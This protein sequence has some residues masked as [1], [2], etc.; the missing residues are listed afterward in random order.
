MLIRRL[1]KNTAFLA[2]AIAM[3]RLARLIII[4]YIG[5]Y[6]GADALGEYSTVMAFAA[7]F[8]AFAVQSLG[9]LVIRDIAQGRFDVGQY[10]GSVTL[11]SLL[12]SVVLVVM[13]N[14]AARGALAS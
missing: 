12:I 4:W 8:Q 14:V 5:R 6:L 1:A 2:F 11:M 10:F 13:M 9:Q 7:M 3:T